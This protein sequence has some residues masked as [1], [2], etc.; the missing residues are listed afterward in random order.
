M[1]NSLTYDEVLTYMHPGKD[2]DEVKKTL[3]S[4]QEI[5]KNFWVY[6]REHLIFMLRAHLQRGGH[7]Y[8]FN[9]TDYD[10][11]VVSHLKDYLREEFEPSGAY[12]Y[13]VTRH[14]EEQYSY[15][16]IDYSGL[17]REKIYQEEKENQKRGYQYQQDRQRRNTVI[18]TGIGAG[19]LVLCGLAGYL[20]FL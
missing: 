19:A 16:V 6:N 5:A 13:Y 9:V 1:S 20:W 14:C 8:H 2:L 18:R 12:I 3:L 17:N 10:K 11:D 15:L 4:S 7:K